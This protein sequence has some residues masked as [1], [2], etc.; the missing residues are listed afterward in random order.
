ME[1]KNQRKEIP[2]LNQKLKTLNFSQ[3]YRKGSYLD[4]YDQGDNTWRVAKV[5]DLSPSYVKITYDGYKSVYD[6]VF[7]LYSGL[8]D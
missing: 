5:L 4:V 7:P 3:L 6:E 1:Q 8:N 2:D